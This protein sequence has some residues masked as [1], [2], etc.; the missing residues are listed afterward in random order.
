MFYARPV[1]TRRASRWKLD[2]LAQRAGVSARTVRYY[3]QRGLLPAPEFRGPDTAYTDEHLAR[4]RAIR[5]LQ[6]RHLPLD[7]IEAALQTR[8]VAA[9][10]RIAE[11][12]VPADLLGPAAPA[13][14]PDRDEAPS[15]WERHGL[16]PGLELHVDEAASEEVRALAEA[17]RREAA[18]HLGRRKRQ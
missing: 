16:A 2:E 18:K 15:R 17:L 6:D 10:A 7:A 13:P 4:L 9:V 3:V 14:A 12:E 8:S 1:E 5:V 11:G